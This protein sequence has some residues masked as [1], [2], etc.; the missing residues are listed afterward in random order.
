MK[1]LRMRC[2]LLPIAAAL[3]IG[4]CAVGAP[5]VRPASD[6]ITLGKTTYS[7]VVARMGEAGEESRSRK[8]GYLLRSLV[9]TY[10]AD[11]EPPKVP[12]TLSIKQALFVF[13]DDVVVLEGFVSSFAA[14]HSDFDDRKVGDI[15]KGKTHCDEVVAMLGRPA[16]RG[17]HPIVDEK[18][19]YAIG[20]WFQYA[21]RPA[22]QFKFFK[23]ELDVLCD[24]AGIVKD[25]GYSEHGDR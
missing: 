17:I 3:V 4:G 12:N 21:K 1:T 10:A 13:A 16:I 5:F 7:E 8:N 2:C 24:R 6:A 9:Y 18:D 11:A 20:Y 25:V 19:D 23:K 15:V 22:L 14:D